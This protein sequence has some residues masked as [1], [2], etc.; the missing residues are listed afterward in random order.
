MFSR[1]QFAIY[2][3]ITVSALICHI[4]TYPRITDDNR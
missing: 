1:R 2:N 4:E 3:T